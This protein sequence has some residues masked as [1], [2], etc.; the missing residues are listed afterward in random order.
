MTQIINDSSQRARALDTQRSFIVQAPAGSGKTELLTQRFLALLAEVEKIPEQIVA[1]TFT[2]KAAAEMRH[3]ILQQLYKAKTQPMP[4]VEHEKKTWTLARAV[5]ARSEQSGWDLLE[6]PNRLSIQTIDALAASITNKMP[7]LSRF[8]T[9]PAII[10]NPQTLYLQAARDVLKTLDQQT[11]WQESLKLLL[12]M[13]DNRWDSAERLLADLLACREQWQGYVLYAKDQQAL[14][15][16]LEVSLKRLVEDHL[17]DVE[18]LLSDS[19]KNEWMRLAEFAGRT[20]SP[21]PSPINERGE[22]LDIWRDL[23]SLV[24]TNDGKWRKKIDSSIGFPAPSTVK[25]KEEKALYKEMKQAMANFIEQLSAIPKLEQ[26]LQTLQKLP[27]P[28]YEDHQWA[29]LNALFTLLPILLAQLRVLFQRYGKVDFTEI[30]LSAL[31]ALGQEDNP[32]DLALALDYRIQHLLVDEFQDT[33]II[34]FQLLEKL[35]QAWQPH[36]GRTLFLV[37]DPMQSIY[38][39]RQ[40]DVGLFLQAQRCGIGDI[41]LELIQLTSNFRSQSNLI[42]WVN[43]TFAE[44][45]PKNNHQLHGAVTYNASYAVKNDNNSNIHYYS[46]VNEAEEAKLIAECIKTIQDKTPKASIALLVRARTHLRTLLPSLKKANIA[47]HAVEI[48]YLGERAVVQDLASLTRALLFLYDRIAWLAVLR[49]PWCGMTLNALTELVGEDK[50]ALIWEQLQHY[51]CKTTRLEYV[52]SILK[53]A[54]EQRDRQSLREWIEGVWISLGGPACLHSSQELQDAKTY[55][56]LLDKLEAGDEPITIERITDALARLH[57]P[58]KLH[59]QD[60]PV[61]VMTIHKAKGLEFDQVIITGLER[62]SPYDDKSL[63]AWLETTLSDNESHWF[64]A[65]MQR[66]Q[67]K[68]QHLY[69][70]LRKQEQAKQDY[71]TTRLLYVGVTRAK[72]HLHLVTQLA[73]EKDKSFTPESGSFLNLLWPLYQHA[74]LKTEQDTHDSFDKAVSPAESKGHHLM[75]LS[76]DWMLPNKIKTYVDN[77]LS[78]MNN[79]L[80]DPKNYQWQQP[81]QEVVGNLVHRVLASIALQGLDKWDSHRIEHLQQSWKQYLLE[82]GVITSR[83]N[84][85]LM[86]VSLAIKNT[87]E[88]PKGR[89]ILSSNHIEHQC[90][91]A[92]QIKRNGHVSEGRIDRSFVDKANTRW[93]IDYKTTDQVSITEHQTQLRYY[94]TILSLLEQ[95]TIRYALYFPLSKEWKELTE[96]GVLLQEDYY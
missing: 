40:A 26:A 57:A 38:R 65:S 1:I 77:P 74:F 2:R 86:R 73:A 42:T 67:D 63:I 78:S 51:A 81:F 29:Q 54:L 58:A 55:F 11:P 89:W 70:Y 3:R 21:N 19:L 71:E 59:S 50:D 45:M 25:N 72:N 56:E 6:N 61:T 66:S 90:E 44:L 15:Q 9:Q 94:A 96:S 24:L 75:R 5:L 31:Y 30:S 34:Q 80:L 23:V 69:D 47:Y 36:D 39:F 13:L 17:C 16:Q 32:T 48:D 49:A 82:E 92:L 33:S 35:T 22:R 84:E 10:E 20:L 8:G 37:G 68:R 64:I 85:A 46:V 60:N 12:R 93:I 43:N 76:Q 4:D 88:D 27:S 7:L 87:L 91:W 28:F 18:A 62:R 83:V 79:N 41:Q 52:I 95:R 14:K 53:Q